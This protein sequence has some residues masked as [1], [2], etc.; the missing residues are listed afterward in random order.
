MATRTVPS[1]SPACPTANYTLTWWDEPQNYI[2]NFINVTV[3]NGEIV[4]MGQLPLN[5]W[6]TDA[7][8][9]YVFN[10][11]NRNG[12]QDPGEPGIP[13]FALTMRRRDNSL[14]DRGTTAV[15]HRRH[16]LLLVRAPPTRW[17]SGS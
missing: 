7:T 5:G 14:M 9:G 1:P 4:D 10:D 17:A 11:L 6:W 15:V 16:R 13:N 12:V 8:T 2:L 3:T